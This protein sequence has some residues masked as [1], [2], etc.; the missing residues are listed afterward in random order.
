M[1]KVN[2]ISSANN[3]SFCF[4]ARNFEGYCI[5]VCLQCFVAVG[6]ALG[7]GQGIWP[8]KT[9]WW[10]TGMVIYVSARCK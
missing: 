10:G 9:E 3:Y 2:W 7:R 4:V 6:W 5:T 1:A 8:V